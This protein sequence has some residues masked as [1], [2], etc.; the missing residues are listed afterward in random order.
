MVNGK[1][2]NS[3]DELPDANCTH[4][5][6]FSPPFSLVRFSYQ[7]E[8]IF[9]WCE[10]KKNFT[11]LFFRFMA[12]ASESWEQ[13]SKSNPTFIISICVKITIV[14]WI[15]CENPTDERR[16]LAGTKD[17]RKSHVLRFFF[18]IVTSYVRI[19]R[20]GRASRH[21][22]MPRNIHVEIYSKLVVVVRSTRQKNVNGEWTHR[23]ALASRR[24]GDW[25]EWKVENTHAF[26]LSTNFLL[27]T[28]SRP[29]C[30]LQ[31]TSSVCC[32][33]YKSNQ[34]CWISTPLPIFSRHSKA[35]LSPHRISLF[36]FLITFPCLFPSFTMLDRFFSSVLC[37]VRE[38]RA[39]F[40][41]MRVF[42]LYYS[43]WNR[44]I[45]LDGVSSLFFCQWRWWKTP[46]YERINKRKDGRGVEWMTLRMQQ[47]LTNQYLSEHRETANSPYLTMKTKWKN[48]KKVLPRG[49]FCVLLC[50][51]LSYSSS[52][53]F[54]TN[55][56]LL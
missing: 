8:N 27:L 31:S 22:F 12:R 34:E 7:L 11:P 54:N 19:K 49:M 20:S 10:K 15:D 16:T 24:R 29:A 32:V 50:C 13:C 55:F 35:L 51:T 18:A 46:K 37:V 48:N 45:S 38:K 36:N 41:E 40:D 28:H 17:W 33:L 42:L 56:L 14:S 30:P 39:P 52:P 5:I 9:M 3:F 21:C 43:Q 25:K 26:P 53:H 2:L 4:T 44:T 47:A 6:F 23:K 1:A